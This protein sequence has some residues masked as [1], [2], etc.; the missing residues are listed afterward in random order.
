MTPQRRQ[1]AHAVTDY[2]GRKQTAIVSREDDQV[3]LRVGLNLWFTVDPDT[4]AAIGMTFL[5][6]AAAAREQQRR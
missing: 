2:D 5:E 4:A 3:T 6:Q 1:V